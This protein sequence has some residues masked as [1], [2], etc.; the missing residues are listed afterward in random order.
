MKSVAQKLHK[1]THTCDSNPAVA[2][3]ARCF[4][5]CRC[6]AVTETRDH[7][8]AAVH[9]TTRLFSVAIPPLEHFVH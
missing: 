2:V 8:P 9:G 3:A 1:A 6:D 5:D 7:Q 4:D